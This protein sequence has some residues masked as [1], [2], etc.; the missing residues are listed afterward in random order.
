MSIQRLKEA[1]NKILSRL[2]AVSGRGEEATK[3]ALVLPMLESLGYDIWNPAEVCP[4]YEADFSAKKAGQKEKVDYGILLNNMPRIY[5]EV[6][7]Y[8]IDLSGHQGQLARYFNSTQTVSLG[9]LT[10]GIEYRFYTDTVH[11][12]IMDLDPFHIV[13]LESS[14]QTLETLARFQKHVFSP[15]AMRDYAS[16]LQSTARIVN[17]FRTELDIKDSEASDSLVRWVMDSPGMFEGRLTSNQLNRFRPIV[18]TALQKVLREIVRRSVAALDEEVSSPTYVIPLTTEAL[19]LPNNEATTS[20]AN[21]VEKEALKIVT[22]EAELEC[23]SIIKK[24]FESHSVSR[25]LIVDPSTKKEVPVEINY[26]DTS[27]YFGIYLNKSNWW[28]CR[29]VIEGK[30]TW[31]GFDLDPTNASFIT[32]PEYEILEEN[33]LCRFRVAINKPQ[34]IESLKELIIMACK[35]TVEKIKLLSN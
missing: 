34:A 29:I 20:G 18:K 32:P 1:S 28:I 25:K 6:K 17:F 7:A 3:Q 22:T 23:F 8:K 26:K 30:R 2:S 16:E 12:N 4:E 27:Y 31:I 10:N 13:N 15:E 19:P 14:E 5:I 11:P 9:I 35:Q 21:E 33:S 24:I